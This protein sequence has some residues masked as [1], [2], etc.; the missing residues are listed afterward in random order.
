METSQF[1]YKQVAVIQGRFFS[2]YDRKTEYQIGKTLHQEA[3][4]NHQSGYYVYKTPYQ[5]LISNIP[6]KE[7]G[8]FV[9][10]RTI[11]KVIAWGECIEYPNHKF[12]FSYILPVE[13]IGLPFGY[14]STQYARNYDRKN[15]KLKP[16]TSSMKEETKKLEEE[17]KKL[18]DLAIRMGINI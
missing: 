5:A 4:P 6:Y 9:A 8:N 1:Y 12:S 16:K 2:I 7:G 13:D 17:V 3:A 18:E 15:A 10:P 14:I 11:L